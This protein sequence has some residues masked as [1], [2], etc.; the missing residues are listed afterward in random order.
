MNNI[1]LVIIIK[2]L[3]KSFYF[4]KKKNLSRFK[5]I[6]IDK[7][8]SKKNK[9]IKIK[10]KKNINNVKEFINFLDKDPLICKEYK[11]LGICAYGNSCKFIHDR[12][13]IGY[14][15]TKY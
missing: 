7:K 6:K 5:K 12:K 13:I 10:Y 11:M 2:K 3:P 15:N 4:F 14:C 8:I 9:L 1:F